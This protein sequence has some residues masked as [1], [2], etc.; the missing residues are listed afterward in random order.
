MRLKDLFCTLIHI[1]DRFYGCLSKQIIISGMIFLFITTVST[2]SCK[3]DELLPDQNNQEMLPKLSDYKIFQGSPANLIPANDY[4]LYEMS[5]QLFT[6]YAEKQRLIKVP[7]TAN[8]TATGDGLPHFPDGTIMVK[9]FYYYLDKRA[10]N[11]GKNIIETRVMVKN[12]G[13]WNVGVYQWNDEQTEGYLITAGSNKTVNYID[14]EGRSKAI[15]Y[16]IP[17]NREC[18]TCHNSKGEVIPIGPKVR[19]LNFEVVRN[20]RS[21]NQLAYLQAEGIFKPLN[22]GSFSAL[23][24]YKDPAFSLEQRARAYLDINCAHCHSQTG[25][26]SSNRYRMEYET[27]LENSKIKAG[28]NAIHHFMEKGL[29]PKIGTTVVDEEGVALIK[30]YLDTL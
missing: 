24:D 1:P 6:D 26:A 15:A 16:H 12:D 5:S 25:F 17:G 29:M 27:S 28:K 7:G 21:E 4:K 13:V 18:A 22:P 9:T 30:K 11:K 20:G 14:E 10:Q 2:V 3:K 8:L 23:P 19:N